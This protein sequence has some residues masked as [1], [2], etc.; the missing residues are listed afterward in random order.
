MAW[1]SLASACVG[2]PFGS[3]AEP[4]WDRL[5]TKVWRGGSRRLG[6]ARRLPGDVGMVTSM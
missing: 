2:S 3:P 1:R 6:L 5:V 4:L